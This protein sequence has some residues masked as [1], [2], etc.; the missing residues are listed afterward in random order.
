MDPDRARASLPRIY[1]LALALRDLDADEAL[2]ADCLDIEPSAVASLLD[3][4]L[5]KQS[6]LRSSTSSPTRANYPD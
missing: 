1:R 4:G 6:R 2:I 3:I 5:R